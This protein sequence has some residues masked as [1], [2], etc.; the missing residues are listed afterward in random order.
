M[1]L[2][3]IFPTILL[4]FLL[5]LPTAQACTGPANTAAVTPL[6]DLEFPKKMCRDKERAE[7]EVVP[8]AGAPFNMDGRLRWYWDLDNCEYG[9]ISGSTQDLVI[10]ISAYARN[11]TWLALDVEPKQIV[12]T[13]QD[14]WDI[15]DDEFDPVTGK[16][17]VR[18]DRDVKV[19]IQRIGAPTGDELQQLR[20]RNGL[21]VMQLRASS[22]ETP[23][24]VPGLSIEPFT[25]DASA[26]AAE[27]R[28]SQDAPMLPAGAMV[29]AL[30]GIAALV[31]RR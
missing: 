6:M 11:P 8:A 22:D 27:D 21:V 26:V 2:A 31:R 29:L 12:L 16:Y 14:Q 7:C 1:R 9:K 30:A 28:G 24:F 17:T 13:F 15:Q 23:D 19:T 25:F 20:N 18:E 5:L 10:N 4:L 3:W